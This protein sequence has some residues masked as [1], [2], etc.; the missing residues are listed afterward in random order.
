MPIHSPSKWL[1]FSS[2]RCDEASYSDPAQEIVAGVGY[3]QCAVAGDANVT[4]NGVDKRQPSITAILLSDV[5][6]VR[7]QKDG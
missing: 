7:T 2:D 4:W 5:G 1:S 3:E 6:A